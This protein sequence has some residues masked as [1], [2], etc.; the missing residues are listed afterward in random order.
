MP[1]LRTFSNTIVC[2]KRRGTLAQLQ[3]IRARRDD[4]EHEPMIASTGSHNVSI[5]LCSGSP[6]VSR[7]QR[8]IASTSA[9]DCKR[10]Q[11]GTA[12]VGREV[13]RN[14]RRQNPDLVR[15]LRSAGG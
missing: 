2:E 9:D 8:S 4:C 7:N 10:L 5:T 3:I 13:D 6:I 12:D 11:L 1:I 14:H 15:N